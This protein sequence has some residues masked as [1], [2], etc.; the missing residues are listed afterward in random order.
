MA[1][2]VHLASAGFRVLCIESD[3]GANPPVG[4]SLDWSAPALLEGLGLPMDR[5]IADNIAI[6]KRHVMVKLTDGSSRHY[7]VGEW[8]E[9]PPYNVERRTLH[10]DRVQLDNRL[11]GIVLNA[12]V[13]LIT[14][15]VVEIDRDGRRV[16]AVKT[17]SGRRISSNWFVDASGVNASLFPRTFKSPA[18]TYGPKKV[19]M[20]SYFDVPESSEG[21]TLYMDGQPSYMEWIWE[22]PIHPTVI[23]VGYVASG[24][25]IKEKRQQGLTVE[26]I[27]RDRLA[28]VPR[29]AQLMSAGKTSAPHVTSFQCRVHG[30]L[31]GPNWLIVGE[32]ASM[33][34]PMTANGVTAALRHAAEAAALIIR[35]GR[36]K[37][38]PRV[39]GALYSSRIVNFGRFFNC[40]IERVIYDRAIRRRTGVLTAGRVYTVPA[41]TLNS[42]YSR[43]RPD[44]VV[45]TLL[46]DLVVKLFR[47]AANGFS[48]LCRVAG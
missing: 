24:D 47:A 7:E 13:E 21:T 18:Y 26:E 33:V 32:S 4:E 17:E 10:V 38:L 25:A 29:F 9:K 14:D 1:A 3:A 11:R 45:S 35:H 36:R 12:G 8:L 46:F 41:W 40:G 23:S 31:A 30:Q 39:A 27:Y 37:R 2:S 15:R 42:I 6:Y 20:W 44:G 22:I 19:A 28:R 43:L 48:A 16:R 34:D 5:L